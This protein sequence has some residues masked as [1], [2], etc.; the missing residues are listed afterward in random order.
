MATA[1]VFK[2]TDVNL[3][4]FGLRP[5]STHYFYYNNNQVTTMVKQIG[6][7]LGEPLIADENG[8]LNVIFYHSSGIPSSSAKS[9]AETVSVMLAGPQLF[10][11]TNLNVTSLPLNFE[12]AS[13]SYAKL[14]TT[15]RSTY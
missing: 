13:S 6:K 11:V 7:K 14:L 8:Y 15:V 5:L 9:F 2:E 3:E 12:S 4:F 10:V 1:L